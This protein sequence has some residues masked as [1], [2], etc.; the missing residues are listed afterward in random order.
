MLRFLRLAIF[1]YLSLK[2]LNQKKLEEQSVAENNKK[3][4]DTSVIVC[5]VSVGSVERDRLP[6]DVAKYELQK[7][8]DLRYNYVSTLFRFWCPDPESDFNGCRDAWGNIW[9]WNANRTRFVDQYNN[10]MKGL[11]E[12]ATSINPIVDSNNTAW[13]FS[14]KCNCFHVDDDLFPRQQVTY[15]GSNWIPPRITLADDFIP[16][17]DISTAR[18]LNLCGTAVWFDRWDHRWV[19]SKELEAWVD[20]GG[21]RVRQMGRIGE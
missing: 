2:Y 14:C 12:F 15:P 1:A 9:R 20:A 4:N 6:S 3:Q 18:V 10:S 5:D 16:S 19:L 11:E 7:E 13:L 8:T 17:A 21:L